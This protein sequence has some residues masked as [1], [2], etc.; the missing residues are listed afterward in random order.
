RAVAEVGQRSDSAARNL[1]VDR[2]EQQEAIVGGGVGE[3]QRRHGL[4]RD[5]GAL[6]PRPRLQVVGRLRA[7]ERDHSGQPSTTSDAGRGTYPRRSLTPL[8]AAFAS[9]V[10]ESISV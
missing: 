7:A 10:V 4:V 8:I 1:P 5:D 6:H 3:L 9:T 2:G